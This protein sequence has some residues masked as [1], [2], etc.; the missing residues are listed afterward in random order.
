MAEEHLKL[1][2]KQKELIEKLVVMHEEEGMQPAAARILS[3]LLVSH[4]PELTFDQIT[5]TLNISKSATSNAINLLLNT[6]QIEYITKYGERKRYFRNKIL[7]WEENMKRKFDKMQDSANLLKEVLKNRPGD[8]TDFN[9]R[10]RE[11]IDFI[12]FLHQEL[13]EIYRKWQESRK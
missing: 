10:L 9:N 2:E 3:L 1:T 7:Q 12:E 4:Q 11:V 6:N 13:P 8:T 5:N